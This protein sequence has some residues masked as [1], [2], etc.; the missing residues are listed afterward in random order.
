LFVT[1]SITLAGGICA[2][3]YDEYFAEQVNVN[4]VELMKRYPAPGAGGDNFAKDTWD[5]LH[6]G[7]SCGENI[8]SFFKCRN[9][10][11]LLWN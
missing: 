10:V 1:C 7:V 2:F 3:E 4:M 6:S 8:K 9:L 5:Q 11:P